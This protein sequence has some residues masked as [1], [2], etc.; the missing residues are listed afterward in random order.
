[1]IVVSDTTPLNYLIL[2]ET[3]HV[4][5][6]IFGRVYIPYAVIE[7][8]S[9]RRSPEAVRTW[10]SSPPEWITV[11]D[12][13]HAGPSKLGRGE[14]A[15]ISLEVELKAHLVL[16]DD[17]DG[18][19]EAKWM[20]LKVVGT[21]GFLEETAK[22]GIID[23]EQTMKKLKETNS[24]ASDQLYQNVLER[25]SQQKLA[26]GETSGPSPFQVPECGWPH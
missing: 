20:G 4:L 18:A 24:R 6:A 14:M 15:A 1:M 16:I 5:P 19:K 22:R 9:H 13:T 2:T 10:G 25:V 12:P 21:L 7:E 11:Q 3:V 23:I 26:G 8:L 17:R